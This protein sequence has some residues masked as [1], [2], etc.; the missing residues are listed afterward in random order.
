[1][2]TTIALSVLLAFATPALA[3]EEPD[4]D[5]E[6]A[7]VQM[8]LTYC[9]GKDWE[10]ADAELNAVWKDAL[11]QAQESD[12]NLKDMEVNDDRPGYVD[13]LRASQRAWISYRDEWC[14]Y[15]GYQARGGSME[16]MLVAGCMAQLTRDRTKALQD[17]MEGLGN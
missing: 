16:P 5:C 4:I 11:A 2:K 3:E 10:E 17:N 13:T 1:M 15:D 9:A 8:E 6:N 12:Q 14:A 7:E